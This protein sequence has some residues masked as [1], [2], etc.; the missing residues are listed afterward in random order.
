[1]L[2]YQYSTPYGSRDDTGLR[3]DNG[4]LSLAAVYRFGQVAPALPVAAAAPPPPPRGR[5]GGGPGGGGGGA[6]GAAGGGRGG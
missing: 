6:G 2:E 3:M 4:L 5:G 1:R